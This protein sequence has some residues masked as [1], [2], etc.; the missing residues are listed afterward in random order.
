[1]GHATIHTLATPNPFCPCSS[2]P[3]RFPFR[4]SRPL[5]YPLLPPAS[6]F[7]NAG[8]PGQAGVLCSATAAGIMPWET[9]HPFPTINL[10]ILYPSRPQIGESDK[11]PS[12]HVHVPCPWNKSHPSIH[13]SMISINGPKTHNRVINTLAPCQEVVARLDKPD[14]QSQEKVK[15]SSIHPEWR[16]LGY[17]H[18]NMLARFLT[19]TLWLVGRRRLKTG[20]LEP[21]RAIRNGR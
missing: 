18:S 19:C 21:P 12:S 10:P 11:G 2:A 6:P 9:D 4:A 16:L 15:L 13:L 14:I 7:I 3:P 8:I 1:M 20:W 17:Q 5:V